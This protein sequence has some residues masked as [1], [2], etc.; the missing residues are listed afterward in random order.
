MEAGKGEA[1]LIAFQKKLREILPTHIITHAP[2]APYF[3][4]EYYPNGGYVTVHK[5]VGNLIDFYNVQ[6][7]NQGD[8]KYDSYEALFLQSGSFFSGTS[9]NEIIKRGIPSNKIVVG[10]PVTI[11]DAANTG[12]VSSTD[13]GKWIS[14]AYSSLRWYAGVMYWQY[15]SDTDMQAIQNSCGYLKQQCETSKNCK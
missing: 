10:K 7:Y 15:I 3:K 1:W 2:Q 4:S 6:F 14:T 8:T 11:A 13:L 9:V 5:E 12:Y